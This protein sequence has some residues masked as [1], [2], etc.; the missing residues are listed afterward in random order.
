LGGVPTY[1]FQNSNFSVENTRRV[2]GVIDQLE[3]AQS[4]YRTWNVIIHYAVSSVVYYTNQPAAEQINTKLRVGALISIKYLK[5]YPQIG[6]INLPAED[7][8]FAKDSEILLFGGLISGWVCVYN[9]GIYRRTV[10]NR[11]GPN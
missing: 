3:P 4:R 10:A 11:R 1:F 9:V 8:Y 5:D 6:R 2:Y 7:D